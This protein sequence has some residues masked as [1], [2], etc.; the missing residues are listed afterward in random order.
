MTTTFQTVAS[1]DGTTI[2]FERIGDGSPVILIGGA[3]NDRS[4]VAGLAVSLAGSFTAVT[5]DR[6]G[7]GDSARADGDGYAVER[8]IEDLAALIA[9]V[10]GPAHVFGHSS[11]AVLGIEAASRGLPV[12]RL[13][14]YEP[15]YV[16]DDS[17]PRP[18][19]DLFDRIRALVEKDQ[20]DEAAALFLTEGAGLPPEMVEGM[21]ADATWGWLT[22]LAHTLPY[23]VAACGPGCV[24]PA[25]RLATI[26]APT[27][28]L[29][30]GESPGWMPAAARAVA[31]AVPEGRYRT[32]EGEDH[33]VLRHPEVLR[34]VLTEFFGDLHRLTP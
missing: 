4:T 34:P 14:V 21:R 22:G 15:P 19:A 26:T 3:F 18:A 2:A 9:E 5:Y 23:D 6:R 1:A 30:G 27:L 17:R 31:A 32:I 7:R 28:A 24:L 20:R 16:V 12:D 29:G 13:A 11:G 25:D 10:G 8:E 33:G